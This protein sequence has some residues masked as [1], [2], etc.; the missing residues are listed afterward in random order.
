MADVQHVPHGPRL[1][2]LVSRLLFAVAPVVVVVALLV[3]LVAAPRLRAPSDVARAE[4][5]LVEVQHYQALL[6]LVDQQTLH[7]S[8]YQY[9]PRPQLASIREEIAT[10]ESGVASLRG[11]WRRAPAQARAAMAAFDR[12]AVVAR[13]GLAAVDAGRSR[14]ALQ[15]MTER[16]LPAAHELAEGLE[17]IVLD[18]AARLGD[19]VSELAGNV[20]TSL[21]ATGLATGLRGFRY[22]VA[23]L[24]GVAR[25]EDLVVREAAAY[26][27]FIAT[28]TS[29][30]LEAV[31]LAALVSSELSTL[32]HRASARSEDT[33]QQALH[34]LSSYNARV[35]TIGERIRH[36]TESGRRASAAHLFESELDPVML[37]ELLPGVSKRVASDR[38]E[39]AAQIRLIDRLADSV[40]IKIAAGALLL[41]FVLLVPILMVGRST[42]R[43]LRR[44]SRAA[45]EVAG[46]N[47]A[48]RTGVSGRSEVG[49]L[50][51]AFDTMA[52]R[53]EQGRAS[54]MSTAVLEASSDL[55]LIVRDGTVT[56]AS[57]ASASLLGIPSATITGKPLVELVHPEDAELLD[58]ASGTWVE[59]AVVPVRLATVSGWVDTEVAIVDLREDPEVRGLALSI[60]DVT[61]RRQAELA[62]EEARD[63]AVE[64]SRLK[65]N[66]LATMSHEIRTPM[67]GV[68][69]LTGLLLTT[70]LDERQAQYAQGV[71]GAGEALLAIIND[72]LDFSK[73]EA[74]KLELEEIDFDLVQVV[75]EAAVLVDGRRSAEGCRAAGLLRARPSAGGA[76]GP[77]PRPAGAAQPRLERGQVHR[78]R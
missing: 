72:I 68:I 74:G 52:A 6:N 8:E 20:Q 35:S 24:I 40:R 33:E 38:T 36:L 26:A 28:G 39:L 60:R 7:W 76:W 58:P 18:G 11:D 75:E 59:N 42:V 12:V 62:L 2:S 43:P 71:R 47:L 50:A 53:V 49:E 17:G 22:E 29:G 64:G 67:N 55:L 57:G 41:M 66:F 16:V 13:T 34:Q 63:A 69:G 77:H 32:E 44:I 10:V 31:G 9:L 19:T 14:T 46:G 21:L 48:A 51:L 70:D 4:R 61:E 23:E 73:V 25:V 54:L 5:E 3:A 65:S 56:Y 37:D 45:D 15:V 78:P 1:R 27:E 30:H